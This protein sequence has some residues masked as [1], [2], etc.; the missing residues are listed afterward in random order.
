VPKCAA[1]ESLFLAVQHP[2]EAEDGQLSSFE[3]PITR[4][5]DFKE[6]AGPSLRRR[7]FE[8]GRRQNRLVSGEATND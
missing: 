5:P 1:D 7:C 2:G 8:A 4:W 6:G 3:N